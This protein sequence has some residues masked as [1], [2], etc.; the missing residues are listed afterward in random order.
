MTLLTCC[1]QAAYNHE[2]KN[3]ENKPR[4][5][6][7][8]VLTNFRQFDFFSY[9]GSTFQRDKEMQVSSMTRAEFFTGMAEG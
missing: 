8:A 5:P 7:H 6:V 3:D 2:I 4:P 1:A 9:D